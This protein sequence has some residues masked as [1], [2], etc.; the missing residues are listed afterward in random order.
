MKKLVIIVLCIGGIIE[1]QALSINEIMSNPVGDD[2]GREWIELYNETSNP[3]DISTL[4]L[5]V[6]GGTPIIATPVSGGVSIPANGYAIIGSTVSGA[7][8]FTQDYPNYNGV[9]F[10]S[11]ISLVNTGVTSLSIRINGVQVNSIDSYTAAKEGLT[12]SS[13]AGNFVTGNPTPGTPNQEVTTT[14]TESSTNTTSGSETT[15]AQ[16]SPPSPDIILYVPSEK[17]LVA[18]G[19]SR[20]SAQAM[21]RKGDSINNLN[22]SWAFGDGGQGV[23]S[24]TSYRYLYPGRYIVHV[25]ATNGLV[26]GTGRIVARVVPPDIAIT[27]V[28]TSKYGTYIDINNPNAY[29][30]DLSQWKISIDGALFSF[31][32][33]TMLGEGV[34]T[35]FSGLRMGFASTT[36]S[37]STVVR[38]LFPNQEEVVRYSHVEEVLP[39]NGSGRNSE[40]KS[41]ATETVVTKPKIL[42]QKEYI[43]QKQKT[44]TV[45][46]SSFQKKVSTTKDTRIASFLKS[47]FNK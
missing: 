39:H 17:I 12:L 1:A 29:T 16:M 23:G 3:V 13:M 31:P 36:V 11:S 38:I 15:V 33:N 5:S 28:G 18:G 32:N 14:S 7:T 46:S 9:L 26:I 25:E 30:L 27:T 19:E 22:Y 44:L 6:K 34:T 47:I 4:T 45:S 35:R 43:S 37:S 41:V 24:S 20:F 21:N 42:Q 2:S 10:K 8:K 40:V